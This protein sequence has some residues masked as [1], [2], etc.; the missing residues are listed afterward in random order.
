M[1]LVLASG[2]PRRAQLL[3]AAGYA[4]TVDEPALDEASLH[5]DVAS[6]SRRAILLALAKARRVAE[7]SPE[8]VVLGADTLVILGDAV[9]GKPRDAAEALYMLSRLSGSSHEVVTGV[10]VLIPGEDQRTGFAATRVTFGRWPAGAM[11]AYAASGAPLD[12]AGAYGIQDAAGPWI[13]DLAGCY[14]NVV[15]LPLSLVARLLPTRI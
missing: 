1:R 12:K 3:A 9:L 8:R 13:Q 5:T 10:A 4:F 2:S 7:R 11:A 6:P 14:F 15:G